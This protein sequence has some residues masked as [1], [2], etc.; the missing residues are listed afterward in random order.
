MDLDN[1][2]QAQ[3]SSKQPLE[4]LKIGSEGVGKPGNALRR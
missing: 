4:N 1:V 3:A 2:R